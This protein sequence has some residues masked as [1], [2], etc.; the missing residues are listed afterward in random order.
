MATVG[1]ASGRA[2]RGGSDVAD[3][4]SRAAWL[5]CARDPRSLLIRAGRRGRSFGARRSLQGVSRTGR[6]VRQDSVAASA[7]SS[8]RRPSSPVQAGS[9]RVIT[10]ATKWAS[11]LA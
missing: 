5:G 3:E 9:A 10:P 1:V 4:R 6:F 8:A 11:S 7:T 2:G